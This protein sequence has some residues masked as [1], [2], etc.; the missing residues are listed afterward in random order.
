M[1]LVAGGFV[2]ASGLR[3]IRGNT[4]AR[5]IRN[6]IIEAADKEHGLGVAFLGG[7]F[8]Q[9][10]GGVTLARIGVGRVQGLACGQRFFGR[11]AAPQQIARFGQCLRSGR[12]RFFP[13]GRRCRSGR[14]G[15][16]LR[17]FRRGTGAGVAGLSGFGS[18]GRGAV[19]LS[20][21]AGAM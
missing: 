14:G 2:P 20:S 1:P 18:S 8:Q 4:A 21:P 10:K 11:R 3:Q 16:V 5:Q 13:R 19:A 9:Q 17:L 7:V 15:L 6:R 12:G